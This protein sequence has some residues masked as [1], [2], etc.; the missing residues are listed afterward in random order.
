MSDSSREKGAI[1]WRVNLRS[2]REAVFAMLASAAGRRRFWAESAE[3]VSPGFIE[4]RFTNGERWVGEVLERIEPSRFA[5]TY[6]Q[7]S[8]AAFDLVPDGRGGTDLCLSE[9]GVSP[10]SWSENHAGWV[11]VLLSLKA[12]VDHS[13]DLRNHD[14]SRTWSHGYVDV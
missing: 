4:F 7:G 12:T 13:I 3:E 11:S 14:S 9:S 10:E 6:F 1:R 2:S 5:V 8:V